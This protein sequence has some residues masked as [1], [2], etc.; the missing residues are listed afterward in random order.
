MPFQTPSGEVVVNTCCYDPYIQTAR[1]IEGNANLAIRGIQKSHTPNQRGETA[2]GLHWWVRRTECYFLRRGRQRQRT[3]VPA[4]PGNNSN[5]LTGKRLGVPGVGIEPT[6]RGFS[7]PSLYPTKSQQQLTTTSISVR[8]SQVC[9]YQL[10]PT[11]TN[12]NGRKTGGRS[13]A[14]FEC[15]KSTN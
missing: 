13:A 1:Q 2:Q 14:L 4:E 8:F 15:P 12:Q 5:P 10:L 7:V 11:S 3:D 9:T 6:T